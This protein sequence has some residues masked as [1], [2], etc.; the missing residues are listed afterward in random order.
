MAIEQQEMIYLENWIYSRIEPLTVTL[1][2]L[3]DDT[4]EALSDLKNELALIKKDQARLFQKN[5]QWQKQI[6][7]RNEELLQKWDQKHK[8]LYNRMNR[9]SE[10]LDKKFMGFPMVICFLAGFFGMSLP[11]LIATI[12]SWF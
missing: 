5:E 3:T 7:L 2:G 10:D 4:T 11:N 1:T 8:D 12:A 9:I 6:E